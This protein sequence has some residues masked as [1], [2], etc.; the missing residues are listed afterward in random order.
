LRLP[1]RIGLRQRTLYLR[2]RAGSGLRLRLDGHKF[3]LK[4]ESFIRAD[5]ATI[6]AAFTVSEE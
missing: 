4:D 1:L 6:R 2:L 5:G 3:N